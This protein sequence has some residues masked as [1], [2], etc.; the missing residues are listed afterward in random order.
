MMSYYFGS[1]ERKENEVTYTLIG[2]G[3]FY[4]ALMIIFMVESNHIRLLTGT[5]R[6]RTKIKEMIN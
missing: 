3:A 4:H 1:I 6:Q 2:S 5:S